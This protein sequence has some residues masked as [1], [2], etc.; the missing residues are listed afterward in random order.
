M[1]TNRPQYD[2]VDQELLS[3]YLDNQ[4][5]IAERGAL[6]RRL[7][8]DRQLQ[9]ELQEL[10]TVKLLLQEL[11]PVAPPRS[12]TLDP[13]AARPRGLPIFGWLR[14]S[15]A[16]ATLL[17]MLMFGVEFIRSGSVPAATAP[18]P[19]AM[20]LPSARESATEAPAA[21]AQ[22]APLAAAEPTAAP[23]A[24]ALELPQGTTT[25][26]AAT[27]LQPAATQGPAA[28]PEAAGDSASAFQATAPATPAPAQAQRIEAT[29]APAADAAAPAGG[30]APAPTDQIGAT[31]NS[32]P[33]TQESN[34][35][36][37][38]SGST[39]QPALSPLRVAQ[40]ALAALALLSAAGAW[41]AWRM[42]L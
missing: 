32:S 39:P 4:L 3:A 6:E 31:E 17:L 42:G 29:P 35:P 40:I 34:L 12:F 25:G 5:S 15:S 13:Q 18:A 16:L 21:A 11:Q 37:A 27:A 23:A 30:G 9:A 26:E 22:E 2:R 20:E 10:R 41:I 24:G 19:S 1:T 33:D 7:Q 14:L 36:P 38:P 28:A 8:D